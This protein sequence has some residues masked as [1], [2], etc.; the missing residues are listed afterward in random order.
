MLQFVKFLPSDNSGGV[1][2][3][4]PS[5]A[6]A[7]A[8]VEYNNSACS[9]LLRAPSAEFVSVMVTNASAKAFFDS[10]LKNARRNYDSSTTTEATLTTS[11]RLLAGGVCVDPPPRVPSPSCFHPPVWHQQCARDQP[12]CVDSVDVHE[13]VCLCAR[14]ELLIAGRSNRCLRGAR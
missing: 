14:G 3:N 2:G 13:Y 11:V 8:T 4:V 1:A 7:V 5:A 10:Y 9:A 6:A 12:L